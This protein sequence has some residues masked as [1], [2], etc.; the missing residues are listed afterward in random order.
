MGRFDQYMLPFYQTSLTQGR[1]YGV[2]ERTTRESLSGEMRRH[3]A[4]ALPPVARVLR[5]FPD[6]LYRTA[7]RVNQNGQ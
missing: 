2:P 3:R 7:R 4:V 6:R 1:K 5:R